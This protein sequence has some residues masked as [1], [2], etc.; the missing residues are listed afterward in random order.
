MERS[1]GHVQ[2][3]AQVISRED[4]GGLP[5]GLA[6]QDVSTYGD[7]SREERARHLVQRLQWLKAE[8]PEP[9]CLDL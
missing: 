2:T 6:R 1:H 8:W 9:Q 5:A 4:H 7:H 3:E